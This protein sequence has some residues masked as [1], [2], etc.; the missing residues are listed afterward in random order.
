MWAAFQ[1][2]PRK[3]GTEV[4]IEPHCDWNTKKEDGRDGSIHP[5]NTEWVGVWEYTRILE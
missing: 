3:M 2:E 1:I 4:E 5:T